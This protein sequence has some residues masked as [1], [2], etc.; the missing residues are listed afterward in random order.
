MKRYVGVVQGNTKMRPDE[1]DS[2]VRRSYA[3][4]AYCDATVAVAPKIADI[5]KGPL[6]VGKVSHLI[7]S[8]DKHNIMKVRVLRVL[9]VVLYI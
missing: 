8:H 9:R 5:Y 1:T 6:D 2:D 3:C 4:I 7:D